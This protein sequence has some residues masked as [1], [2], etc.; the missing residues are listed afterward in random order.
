MNAS[1]NELAEILAEREQRQFDIPFIEE[2][3]VVIGYWR[4]RLLRDALEKNRQDR[5]YFRQYIEVPLVRVNIAELP[6][7][8]DYP[9]LRTACEIP[10]PV[11]ANGIAYDYVGSPDKLSNFKLFTEQHELIPALN[12]T[13]T[14]KN[15][16]GLWL[17][18]FI[19][20]FNRLDLPY[21]GVSGVYDDP[22]SVADFKCNCGCDPCYDDDMPYP[23][24]GDIQQRIIQGILSTEL[25]QVQKADTEVVPVTKA[26]DGT[27][28]T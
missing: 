14:G 16:K 22:Q 15:P 11:R 26:L 6:G 17:N 20:V 9:V 4:S 28:Q 8:P 25:R 5:M 21:L 7:F 2:M 18:K 13:H 3:K 23:I 10:E 24:S 19:Y 12:A 1:L 27:D